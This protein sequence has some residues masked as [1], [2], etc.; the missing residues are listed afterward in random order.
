MMTRGRTF[1][2]RGAMKFALIGP[3]KVAKECA[4]AL[5]TLLARSTGL[6]MV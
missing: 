6:A 3:I 5:R 2:Q 4:W 1:D